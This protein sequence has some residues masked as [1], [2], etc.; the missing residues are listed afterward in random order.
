M[1]LYCKWAFLHWRLFLAVCSRQ[2]KSH[3]WGS[4]LLEPYD[5][6]CMWGS[7]SRRPAQRRPAEDACDRLHKQVTIPNVY[8]TYFIVSLENSWDNKVLFLFRQ[9][10]CTVTSYIYYPICFIFHVRIIIHDVMIQND[11][12]HLRIQDVCC[13][14]GQHPLQIWL[15][16]RQWVEGSIHLTLRFRQI[17]QSNCYLFHY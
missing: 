8:W 7:G 6:E 17:D 10:R 14:V 11:Y 3:V 9:I 4:A 12:R 15:Y 16:A 1:S 5:W 2:I 13:V